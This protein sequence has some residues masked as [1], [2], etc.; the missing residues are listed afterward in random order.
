MNSGDKCVQ[1]N[2]DFKDFKTPQIVGALLRG[3]TADDN[4]NANSKTSFPVI[5]SVKHISEDVIEIKRSIMYNEFFNSNPYPE[6]TIRIN[7]KNLSADGLIYEQYLATSDLK[8]DL[9]RLHSK[10]VLVRRQHLEI[11]SHKAFQSLKSIQLMS[12]LFMYK[13][14]QEL[15]MVSR[16]LKEQRPT[17]ELQV[18][19][20]QQKLKVPFSELRLS[21]VLELI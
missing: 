19:P 11:D 5:R 16:M 20:N 7:R 12:N 2:Y 15:N 21:E 4:Q 3:W 13:S 10:G 8:E 9:T 14:L 17:N 1:L 6:E 18:E